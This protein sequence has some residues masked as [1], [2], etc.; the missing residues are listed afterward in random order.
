M[1]R[2][3]KKL[4]ELFVFGLL[5]CV[6]LYVAWQ[7]TPLWGFALIAIVGAVEFYTFVNSRPNDSISEI[8]WLYRKRTIIPF[9]FGA[10]SLGM[11]ALGWFGSNWKQAVLCGVWFL[12]MGHFF[13]P[14]ETEEL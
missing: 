10:L 2:K 8:I 6:G 14:P 9:S 4:T 7:I 12:L 3:Y 11:I 1:P 5:S 13:F